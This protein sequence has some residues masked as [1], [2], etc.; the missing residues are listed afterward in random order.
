MHS[1]LTWKKSHKTDPS[2]EIYLKLKETKQQIRDNKAK[3]YIAL[4]DHMCGYSFQFSNK[5]CRLLAGTLH[6]RKAGMLI[7]AVHDYTG[8]LIHSPSQKSASF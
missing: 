3:K 1:W 4:R 5:C 2:S 6:P 8:L 7:P